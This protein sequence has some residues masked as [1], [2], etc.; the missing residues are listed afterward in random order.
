MLFRSLEIYMIYPQL[1]EASQGSSVPHLLIPL[2]SSPAEQLQ[3]FKWTFNTTAPQP[4]TR[5]APRETPSAQ[6]APPRLPQPA[7][8]ISPAVTLFDPSG[9]RPT[10]F[11]GA[12]SRPAL[13]LKRALWSPCAAL[14]PHTASITSSFPLQYTKD[15]SRTVQKGPQWDAAHR[16]VAYQPLA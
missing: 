3:S 2:C 15:G 5:R 14:W 10:G 11:R 4:Q 9:S 13:L 8:D 1:N 6:P 16:P 12:P 7:R